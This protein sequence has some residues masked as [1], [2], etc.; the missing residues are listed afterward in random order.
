MQRLGLG[1]EPELPHPSLAQGRHWHAHPAH[2]LLLLLAFAA[3]EVLAGT[4]DEGEKWKY[5]YWLDSCI[6]CASGK[7]MDAKAHQH[8]ECKAC[9]SAGK[10]CATGKYKTGYVCTKK[11]TAAG[12]CKTCPAGRYGMEQADVTDTTYLNALTKDGSTDYCDA[13]GMCC[14]TCKLVK[15]N[16]N[17]C[18]AGTYA[19]GC[20]V[21]GSKG[22]CTGCGAGKY[23]YKV[24]NLQSDCILCSTGRYSGA[25]TASSAAQCI[26]CPVGR[27][28]GVK[29]QSVCAGCAAG[30]YQDAKE[31][32]YC[33][34]CPVGRANENL[35]SSSSSACTACSSGKFSSGSQGTCTSCAAGTFA[36]KESKSCTSCAA[37]AYSADGAASCSACTKGR[38]SPTIGRVSA[39]Q[40]IA[41]PFGK[42]GPTAGAPSLASCSGKCAAGSFSDMAGLSSA[43]QC[44]ECSKGRYSAALGLTS[45]FDCT[46]CPAGKFG[47]KTKA[48][49][50]SQCSDCGAGRFSTRL[51]ITSLLDCTKCAAG[52]YIATTGALSCK[53]CQ[54]GTYGSQLGMQTCSKCAAGRYSGA[55]GRTAA[56]QCIGCPS[57]KFGNLTA[58]TK[59]ADCSGLCPSGKYGA[60]VGKTSASECSLCP[61]GFF[62]KA[63]GSTSSD[64]C[65]VDS[66]RPGSFGRIAGASSQAQCSNCTAGRYGLIAAAS[67]ASQC[68]G[69]CAAGKFSALS[70]LSIGTQCTNCS[71]GRFSATTA[72]SSAGQCSGKCPAGTYGS[73]TGAVTAA[74]CLACPA[75]TFGATPGLASASQCSKCARGKYSS[76]SGLSTGSQCASACPKGRYSDVAGLASASQCKTCAAGRAGA[77]L[78]ASSVA[79]CEACP[80]GKYQ[81]K[82]G[83]A[84]CVECT[85]GRY[86]AKTGSVLQSACIGCAAGRFS[87]LGT[88]VCAACAAGRFAGVDASVCAPCPAGTAMPSNGSSS[89]ASCGAGRYNSKTA[90]VAC[91]ACPAGRWADQPGRRTKS[92]ECKACQKGLYSNQLGVTACSYCPIGRYQDSEGQTIC[93]LCSAGKVQASDGA[94]DRDAHK[95]DDPSDCALCDVDEYQDKAGKGQCTACNPPYSRTRCSF[96]PQLPTRCVKPKL[97]IDVSSM[98]AVTFTTSYEEKQL[99][100]CNNGEGPDLIV[101]AVSAAV[102]ALPFFGT[103]KTKTKTAIPLR[104]FNRGCDRLNIQ[105]IGSFFKKDGQ[106]KSNLTLTTNDLS[107]NKTGVPGLVVIELL[108]TVREADLFVITQCALCSVVGT[109]TSV[110]T[111]D[112]K[113]RNVFTSKI[114]WSIDCASMKNKSGWLTLSPCSG[115]L[116]L[117]TSA[118]VKFVTRLPTVAGSYSANVVVNGSVGTIGSGVWNQAIAVTVKAAALQPN[119]TTISTNRTVTAGSFFTVLIEPR[120]KFGNLVS[121]PNL[122]FRA[123]LGGIVFISQYASTT[124]HAIKCKVSSTGKFNMTVVH[125]A[126]GTAKTA[127]ATIPVLAKSV[128]CVGQE[129]P[130]KAGSA[131]LCR[132]GFEQLG[133]YCSRCAYGKFRTR[134]LQSCESCAAGK[135][136]KSTVG[137]TECTKCPAGRVHASGKVAMCVACGGGA[138]PN[139]DSSFCQACAVVSDIQFSSDGKACINCAAGKIPST[140]RTSCAL[141]PSGRMSGAKNTSSSSG[142]CGKCPA[143]KE[144]LANRTACRSCSSAQFLGSAAVCEKCVPNS[145]RLGKK[146]TCE[147]LPGYTLLGG[148]CKLCAVAKIKTQTSNAACT[149]CAGNK[150]ADKA[151]TK[152]VKCKDNSLYVK[153]GVCTAVKQYSRATSQGDDY[154]CLAG[155]MKDGSGNCLRCLA[156]TAKA[157][158]GNGVCA[159]CGPA[160]ESNAK[161][162]GC[163]SCATTQYALSNLCTRLPSFSEATAKGNSYQCLAGYTKSGS[164]DCVQ[165]ST[166]YAK[167]ASGNG[168]CIPCKAWEETNA[169]R[170]ACNNCSS[171]RYALNRVCVQLPSFSQSTSVGNSY[172]C[173]AG[174]TKDGT[175]NCLR[176]N[177]G[178][179]KATAGNRACITCEKWEE[180]LANRTGCTNCSAVRYS[181]NNMCT[182]LPAFSRAIALGNDYECLAGFAK[183]GSGN[184]IRCLAGSAKSSAGN[185]ACTKCQPAQEPN[186]KRTGCRNCSASRYSLSNVCTKTPGHSQPTSTGD[187]YEC[188][189]GYTK[190]GTGNCNLCAIGKAKANVGNFKCSGCNVSAE[191]FANRSACVECNRATHYALSNI[192]TKLPQNSQAKT[193]GDDYECKV[194]FTKDGVGDCVLCSVGKAKATAGNGKCNDC[195]VNQ[196]ADAARAVCVGCNS[197]LQYARGFICT[198]LPVFS[199]ATLGGDSYACRQGY[200]FDSG[201]EQ[202]AKCD[203]GQ[204]KSAV[205]RSLCQ[206]CASGA[207]A[208]FDRSGCRACNSST[209]YKDD[210]AKICAKLP[211]GSRAGTPTAAIF[212]FTAKGSISR[213]QF[214]S[215]VRKKSPGATILAF[216]QVLAS[217]ISVKAARSDFQSTVQRKNFAAA[218]AKA[219]NATT[220]EL[221]VQW[222]RMS[223]RR[224]LRATA[225]SVSIPF[226]VTTS[227]A[228]ADLASWSSGVEASLNAHGITVKSVSSPA[229]ATKVVLQVSATSDQAVAAASAA[230]A[231]DALTK[232]LSLQLTRTAETVRNSG[233]ACGPGTFK[234][235]DGPE[236]SPDI[237]DMAEAISNAPHSTRFSRVR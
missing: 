64:A 162:T 148:Q 89:C 63:A 18:T 92:S 123:T 142:T 108:I 41:C 203:L 27:A 21:G 124:S 117:G 109:P 179:Y 113:I 44:R 195:A 35:A 176:C 205:D 72:A 183:D 14:A 188:K 216:S 213:A 138:Q 219:C 185:G 97:R 135:Q 34:G 119:V 83:S 91:Y 110:A 220:S 17:L 215:Q 228:P 65:S 208:L 80:G 53:P 121:D 84:A 38:Y 5:G 132:P 69:V 191:A 11:A 10:A 29:G 106:H 111:R 229:V 211:P 48:Q 50:V 152:C 103:S 155:Y 134:A 160:Q 4:C 1:A 150:E 130:N 73:V 28:N 93:K 226:A 16:G 82:L 102:W 222:A 170:V 199:V 68:K 128:V 236:A 116:A 24:S 159:K 61:I 231:T 77:E 67:V 118:K 197:T 156:G 149:S 157:L 212:Q 76:A 129:E 81:S 167:A 235:T 31:K 214:L 173:L 47:A 22:A 165:C 201:S 95:L 207:E 223:G 144:S 57:G 30:K 147:C 58:A 145:V 120:D 227:A 90:Q 168:A 181:L 177:P 202:C 161:R 99:L 143:N 209:E 51:A 15:Y 233:F 36:G 112:F 210:S 190:D 139:A 140:K 45:L 49:T 105:F 26:E 153:A 184:C 198:A 62:N 54:I 234:A 9:V 225:T 66:C 218:L 71:S 74:W 114:K 127:V 169:K 137:A 2:M 87:G 204:Y 154:E 175:G 59:L 221:V 46:Q 136:P 86:N 180:S 94:K 6:D 200:F 192:C 122:V 171:A 166:G 107:Q 55:V 104:G 194:G 141:C 42:F 98:S 189:A 88:N 25:S 33:I 100:I 40:C 151:R 182:K 230:L 3:T 237:C 133:L 52:K 178:S 39:A 8:K 96:C 126:S 32:N 131:C 146:Q 187:D 158:A 206:R 164:G 7:Y 19:G 79:Q 101:S 193:T 174:Y 13:G 85:A 60:K 186:A 20:G 78:G 115:T 196:E 172:E 163:S 232:S 70:G 75:G 37:G 43:G 217:N 125:V 12:A 224:R 23:K 56:A